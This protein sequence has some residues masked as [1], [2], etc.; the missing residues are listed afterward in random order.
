ML[1]T[2]QGTLP[3]AYWARADWL[4][5]GGLLEEEENHPTLR[6]LL[7]Q[8]A[9]H[10]ASLDSLTGWSQISSWGTGGIPEAGKQNSWWLLSAKWVRV[11]KELFIPAIWIKGMDKGLQSRTRGWRHKVISVYTN[12]TCSREWVKRLNRSKFSLSH[13]KSNHWDNHPL[14]SLVNLILTP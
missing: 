12:I 9:C 3:E 1:G 11:F 8:G 4:A 5:S 14:Y 13:F 7:A 10:G 2:F 6:P